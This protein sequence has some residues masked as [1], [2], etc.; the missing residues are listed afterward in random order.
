[1]NFG[2]GKQWPCYEPGNNDA[3]YSICRHGN[4]FLLAGRIMREDRSLSTD[5]AATFGGTH[6]LGLS[7]AGGGQHSKFLLLF[8]ALG[9]DGDR[10]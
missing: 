6:L 7:V 5:N 10:V 9:L 1:V 4:D 8:S 2:D 3:T